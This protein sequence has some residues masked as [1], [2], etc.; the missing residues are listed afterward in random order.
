MLE[1]GNKNA[2]SKFLADFPKLNESTVR[3]F[4]KA[5]KEKMKFQQHQQHPQQLQ[6]FHLL[7]EVVLLYYWNLTISL[8]PL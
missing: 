1:N 2:K 4:K 6:Q 3:H 7:L 8:L 5:Y